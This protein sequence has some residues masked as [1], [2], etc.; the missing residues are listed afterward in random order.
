MWSCTDSLVH[1]LDS[2]FSTL[3]RKSQHVLLLLLPLLLLLA[4][5]LL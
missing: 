2:G 4:V 3:C 1:R 5:L